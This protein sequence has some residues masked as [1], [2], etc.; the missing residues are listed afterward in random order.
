MPFK[1]PTAKRLRLETKTAGAPPE[2]GLIAADDE[3]G[4]VEAIVSVTGVVDEDDDIILPGAYTETLAKRRPKGIFSHDWKRWAS[5]TEAVEEWPPGDPRLPEKTKDGQ[6]W[7]ADAGALYVKTRYNLNTDTGRNAYHDVVFYSEV[8]ECEWS[9]GYRV[10]RGKGVRGKDGIRRISAVD[11]YEYSPVLFG[12][13]SLSGTLSVK[14]AGGDDGDTVDDLETYEPIPGDEPDA[15]AEPE[16]GGQPQQEEEEEEGGEASPPAAED[17]GADG[18]Q[19]E[20]P[21][22]DQ[23]DGEDDD[24]ADGADDGEPE[25][26][27][28]VADPGALHTDAVADPEFERET[29]VPYGTELPDVEPEDDDATDQDDADGEAK[30][31]AFMGTKAGAPGVADTPSDER[32]VAQLK[33][34][35]LRGEGAAQ[36][37]W[38]TGGDFE[39]CVRIAGKHMDPKQAKG[40]CA[41]LHKSATGE[42]PGPS[43]HGGKDAAEV[44][45]SVR[46]PWLPG[47]YEELRDELREAAAKQLGVPQAEADVVATWPDRV[48]VTARQPGDEPAYATVEMPYERVG[49][50]LVLGEPQAVKLTVAMPGE[51]GAEEVLLPYAG[52]LDEVAEGVKALCVHADGGEEKAGRVLSAV[53]ERHLKAAVENLVAVLRRAGVEINDKAGEQDEPRQEVPDTP[54]STAPSAQATKSVNGEMVAVD[55]VLFARAMAVIAD[56]RARS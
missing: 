33:R 28:P 54:D 50:G 40:F 32:S 27:E 7:P 16:T 46:G 47:S 43:A 56:A 24:Q 3:T 4:V 1:V 21:A 49:E 5:R 37:R 52:V 23:A 15:Q 55:P 34:W 8:G 48:V 6:P 31:R 25:D 13:A 36:I 26:A 12:A 11:L 2:S 51:D 39:R 18:E 38:G 35:Y 22:D 19:D 53:N 29:A 14:S 44:V 30:R 41:N 42:W 17:A 45:E 20:P 9:I 10:P